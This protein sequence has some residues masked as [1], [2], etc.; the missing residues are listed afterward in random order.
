[1]AVLNRANGGQVTTLDGG[2]LNV[3]LVQDRSTGFEHVELVGVAS[4]RAGHATSLCDAGSRAMLMPMDLLQR[5]GGDGTGC[6]RAHEPSMQPY[7][8]WTM[9]HDRSRTYSLFSTCFTHTHF[10]G[11]ARSQRG[12]QGDP[13]DRPG[14]WVL[15][16]RLV[17]A[18]LPGCVHSCGLGREEGA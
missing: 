10:A 13:P 7:V 3:S 12:H 11:A 5:A 8:M 18:E 15:G 2:K 14:R 17:Q 4:H 1:M 16:G 6:Y 9:A